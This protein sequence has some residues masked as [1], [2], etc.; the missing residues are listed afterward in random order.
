MAPVEKK[1]VITGW[2]L[3]FLFLLPWWIGMFVIVKA[4][5]TAL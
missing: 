2:P 4:V 5:V 3:I 1:W